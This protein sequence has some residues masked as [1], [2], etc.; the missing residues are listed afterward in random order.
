[1]EFE[2]NGTIYII[3]ENDKPVCAYRPHLK[4]NVTLTK[5]QKIVGPIQLLGDSKYKKIPKIT[6]DNLEDKLP[7]VPKFD[8][9]FMSF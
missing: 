1:M 7:N 9:S 6:T 3:M 5:N 8:P 2:D 4:V